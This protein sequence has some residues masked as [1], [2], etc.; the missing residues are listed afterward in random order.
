MSAAFKVLG[1]LLAAVLSS[2]LVSAWGGSL[3]DDVLAPFGG[4]DISS[5]YDA[6]S[7]FID[8]VIY[9]ILFV[10]ISQAT[11]G[12]RFQGRG[13]K[14][15]VSA[16]GMV[17]ALGLAISERT[18]GFN[19]RSF[20]PLAAGLFIFLVGF[21][22][23]LA[24]K[25]MGVGGVS[26]GSIALVVT[27]F[28]IRAVAPSFFD[29]MMGNPYTSW[30]HAVL[31]IAVIISAYRVIR[32]ILPGKN[33]NLGKEAKGLLGQAGKAP[34]EMMDRIR[35][36]KQEKNFIEA[37]LEKIIEAADKTSRQIL[38]DLE[39]MK[40]LIEEFGATAKGQFLIGKKME[41]LSPKEHQVLKSFASLKQMVQKLS[42]FDWQNYEKLKD[43]Y[44]KM[45]AKARK[46]VEDEFRD[47]WRKIGAEKEITRLEEAIAKYDQNFTH[48]VRMVMASLK[49][50]RQRDA[51]VW[52]DE[53]IKWEKGVQKS[54]QEI[55][56]LEKKLVK[57]T[58]W[59]IK[60]EKR[61]V[62]AVEKA[63]NKIKHI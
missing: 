42:K 14:A 4:I 3:I 39:E 22:L 9:A 33:I 1:L 36:E 38:E 21:C 57:Y 63:E 61:T 44:R 2:R 29:W 31:V 50:N 62:K 53:A 48:A 19:L 8:F 11:L 59:E 20:G 23:Y 10:G 58:K 15:V 32:L 24:I 35:A 47:E 46:Q 6:Y 27:Y 30:I 43:E 40:K 17:L 56:E 60:D 25:T 41:I 7:S 52:I 51:L 12:K 45:T 5:T 26:A 34:K 54:L 28:S 18:L 55:E 16:I 49:A 13:G 37:R